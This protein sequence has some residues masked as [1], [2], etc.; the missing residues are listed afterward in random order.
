[1]AKVEFNVLAKVDPNSEVNL[2]RQLNRMK[3]TANVKID[4]IQAL[5]S[6]KAVQQQ[7]D[8][9]KKSLGNLKLNFSGN[10]NIGQGGS[11]GGSQN[12]NG[13][14]AQFETATLQKTDALYKQISNT[15]NGT[16]KNIQVLRNE[17]GQIVSG[18]VTV[19]NGYQT[20]KRN[21]EFVD[22]QFKR[23]LAS[24][25]DNISLAQRSNTLYKEREQHLKNISSI[26]NKLLTATGDE[27]QVLQQQLQ[28]EQRL[29]K[30][31]ANR[32]SRQNSNG[33]AMYQNNE[34]EARISQLKQ[35]LAYEE[36]LARARVSDRQILTEQNDNYRQ[37]LSL[38]KEIEALTTRSRTVTPD[39]KAVLDAEIQRKQTM[40]SNLQTQ[41]QLTQAQ[42]QEIT[43]VKK[44]ADIE[45]QIIEIKKQQLNESYGN[46]KGDGLFGV[47]SDEL[48]KQTQW[49]QD[50]NKQ[51]NNTAQISKS[52]KTTT[53]QFGES[54][55]QCTVKV[56]TAENQWETYNATINNTTGELRVLKG[57]TSDVINSQM[58]L[59]TMLKSAIERF[60]VWGVAMKFWTGLKEGISDCI[61]YVKELDSAMTNIR[62]VTMDTKEATDGLLKSYNQIGQELGA[63]T[64]DIAEGS[65]EWLRQ[66]FSQADTTELVKD[67]TILSELA[68]IDNA[69][70]TEYLTSALKGY[71]LEA[72]DAIGVIDQLVSIDLEAAT[73]AGDMAEAMS[74][75]SNM[76]RTTGVEMN[77]LLGMIATTAEVTQ[78]SASTVGNAMKTLFSRM[79]NVKA[80]VEIDSETG[81]ALNDVEKVLNRVGIALRD[82]Q[83]NWYDFYDVLNKIA[84]RWDEFSGTQQSQITTALGGKQ[85]PSAVTYSNVWCLAV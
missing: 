84:S 57:Q 14:K 40:I 67:S 55:S 16:V 20:W 64:T 27:R 9:L 72:K 36:S 46:L 21:L 35:Q 22:G 58:N 69:E 49:F 71:K 77:E 42:Q 32:I 65:V 10:T 39:E 3:L 66:G 28:D 26:K 30:L 19:S 34:G 24:G 2:Q 60:A 11:S 82:N 56:K 18:V 51:Y 50:L 31:V 59:S 8:A 38:T 6:I 44:K 45:R 5:Q 68:L 54:I 47:N 78:N 37:Q 4:N 80:G 41:N 74:R 7:V 29:S 23:V 17:Q 33:V 73:S 79:S 62:V 63:S 83:G 13:V 81:E 15:V 61:N 48:I 12:R 75:T 52:V 76:A 1:M 85:K 53:N 25:R 43:E 70:A